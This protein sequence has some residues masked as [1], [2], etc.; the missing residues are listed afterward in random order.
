MIVALACDYRLSMLS[1][2]ASRRPAAPGEADGARAT[3]LGEMLELCDAALLFMLARCAIICS[4]HARFVSRI[5]KVGEPAL[6]KMKYGSAGTVSGSDN[7]S[8]SYAGGRYAIT[9]AQHT[10]PMYGKSIIEAGAPNIG[11]GE[12]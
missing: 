7:I 11:E 12:R 1:S 6:N 3:S 5:F 4:H 10:M 2:A 8:I 9:L